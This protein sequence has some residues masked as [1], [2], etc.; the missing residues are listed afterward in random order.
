MGL[1]E[2]ASRLASSLAK[3]VEIEDNWK[4]QIDLCVIA[5]I[6]KRFVCNNWNPYVKCASARYN[7]DP[8]I[9]IVRYNWNPQTKLAA[10]RLVDAFGSLREFVAI[11]QADT[12][13][14]HFP[15]LAERSARRAALIRSF[16]RQNRPDV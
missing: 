2:H 8:F 6:F 14:L 11:P 1:C 12:L 9:K 7:W 4:Q 15:D 5:G 10:A 16:I 13:E 3:Q